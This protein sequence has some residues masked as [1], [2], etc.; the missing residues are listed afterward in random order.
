VAKEAENEAKGVQG[1]LGNRQ[2]GQN[3]YLETTE[4]R[5]E[6]MVNIRER[7]DAGGKGG[8]GIR[9]YIKAPPPRA[10]HNK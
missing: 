8:G 10:E 5:R 1:I 3:N 6:S 4:R 7:A 9:V 2:E